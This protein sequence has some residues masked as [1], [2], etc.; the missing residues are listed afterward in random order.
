MSEVRTSP[1]D[2]V[3]AQID[4]AVAIGK[5]HVRAETSPVG[6]GVT[7]VPGLDQLSRELV[8]CLADRYLTHD[9]SSSAAYAASPAS[10]A[11]H[12]ATD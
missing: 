10:V 1:P 5:R 11:T 3:A 2:L 4:G 6:S 7:R 8:D 9:H 12:I